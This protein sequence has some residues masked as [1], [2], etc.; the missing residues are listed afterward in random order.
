MSIKLIHRAYLQLII[1]HE[2]LDDPLPAQCDIAVQYHSRS[3][4]DRPLA[5]TA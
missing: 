5:T 1:G 2:G 3:V 4:V